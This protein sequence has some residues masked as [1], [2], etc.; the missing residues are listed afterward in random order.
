ME[1]M[2]MRVLQYAKRSVTLLAAVSVVAL[3]GCG[4]SS[5]DVPFNP[6]G[7]TADVEALNAAFGTSTMADFSSLSLLFDAAYGAPLISSSAAAL[8]IRAGSPAGMRAAAMRSAQ[9]LARLL[10]AGNASFGVVSAAIPAGIAGTTF[11]YSGGA[12]AAGVRTGAPANGVRFILYAVDPVTGLPTAGLEETG[13]VDI[14]DLSG[15]STQSAR[16]QVVSGST[17]YIDYTASANSITGRITVVGYVTDGTNRANLN[18]RTTVTSAG[19]I[20]LVY[21]LDVPQRDVSIDLTVGATN[22]DTQDPTISI[23]LSMSGPNGTLSMIGQFTVDGG[24]LTVR[25]GGTTLATITVTGA[26]EPVI[27]GTD[28]LP[29]TDEEATALRGI[30]DLS[31]QAFAS[32]DQ[33][34][35][36]V[37]F[38]LAPA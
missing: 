33:M 36:P 24:T 30:F 27:T 22:L 28:G 2:A 23:N 29:I 1:T 21:S 12:Y 18:L 32:F 19:G 35:V 5:P 25:N 3:T 6:A 16:V 17:T 9:R 20:T 14:T 13:Y 15:T 37:V 34:L 10:P 31:G 4:D 26:A 11:E 38:F 8:D 7:T